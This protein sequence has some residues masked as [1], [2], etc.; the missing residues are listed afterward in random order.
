[1]NDIIGLRFG[2]L[3]VESF[4]HKVK[5]KTVGNFHYYNCICD[6]GNYKIVERDSL[7]FGKTKSCGCIHSELTSTRNKESAKYKGES[8]SIHARLL[9]IY[10]QMKHRCYNELDSNYINYG[11][12]GIIVCDEWIN[13]YYCF[14]EWALVN[15][16]TDD[17]TIDRIN[18]NGNYEPSNCKW[19]TYKEQANN[20]RTNKM[21]EYHGETKTLSEWCDELGIEYFRTK[22][23]FNT[24]NMTPTQAF[25]LPKQKLRRKINKNN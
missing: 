13:D 10:R 25:E 15:R 14:K 5:K 19:S 17:L 20:T 4:S 24:C 18:V 22:A 3:I 8:S 21:I 23:R 1:V 2:R 11:G 9:R 6:C 7:K 16:Y 12:R